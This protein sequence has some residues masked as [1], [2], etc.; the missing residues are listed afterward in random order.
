[1]LEHLTMLFAYLRSEATR[2]RVEAYL[3]GWS[4]GYKH[5]VSDAEVAETIALA[6][7]LG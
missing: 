4:V 6:A 3:A 7:D 2:E 5:A 1:V